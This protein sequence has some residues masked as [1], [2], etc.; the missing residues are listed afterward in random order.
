MGYQSICHW[1]PAKNKQTHIDKKLHIEQILF[2]FFISSFLSFSRQWRSTCFLS[3]QKK[4]EKKNENGEL[5]TLGVLG[6]I[7]SFCIV[8]ISLQIYSHYDTAVWNKLVPWLYD[9]NEFTSIPNKNDI[10]GCT[11]FQIDITLRTKQRLYLMHTC[12]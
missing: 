10:I 11:F 2:F 3:I 12:I 4:N 5:F 7:V 8:E 6:Y 1:Y 9:T